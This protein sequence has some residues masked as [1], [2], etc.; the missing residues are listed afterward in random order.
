M[1]Q[2]PYKCARHVAQTVY[3]SALSV[4]CWLGCKCTGCGCVFSETDG[5]HMAHEQTDS[6]PMHWVQGVKMEPPDHLNL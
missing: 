1:V 6:Q 5:L 3:A 2:Q 4:E